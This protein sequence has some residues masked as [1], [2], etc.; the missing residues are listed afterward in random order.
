VELIELVDAQERFMDWLEKSKYAD[1][2]A[3]AF[4]STLLEIAE[5][6][7]MEIEALEEAVGENIWM[8]LQASAM[9]NA[10]A[11]T[12]LD[13]DNKVVDGYL[14]SRSGAK[15]SPAAQMYFKRLRTTSPNLYQITKVDEK[16]G[17]LEVVPTLIPGSPIVV[18]S[19][20]LAF[21]ADPDIYLFGRVLELPKHPQFG[22]STVF[23]DEEDAEYARSVFATF[24]QAAAE[25]I[26]E[27]LP[28]GAL[29]M[30][31]ELDRF[32]MLGVAPW[33]LAAWTSYSLES[34]EE[35]DEEDEFD[36]EE[37]EKEELP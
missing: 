36:G 23:L 15:E 19:K 24:R 31:E 29:P 8:F 27:Q 20:E 35:G 11:F 16:A 22:I 32:A 28:Q 30:D 13:P 14:K 3:E 1:D 25:E 18:A 26:K 10:I 4:S 21:R 34:D 9:E 17:T 6:L 12:G 33:A 7:E 5:L 2:L 37:E